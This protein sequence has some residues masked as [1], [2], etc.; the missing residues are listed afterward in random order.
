MTPSH[1]EWRIGAHMFRFEPPDLLRIE[2]K[3]NLSLEEA[4]R[5]V[6]LYRE[7]GAS[8][9]LYMMGCMK[10]AEL[11]EPEVRQYIS[12]NVRSEWFQATV[13]YEARLIHKALIKGVVLAAQLIER[14][15]KSAVDAIQFTSTREQ[16]E[17]LIARLRA[18]RS[19]TDSS[20]P[21]DPVL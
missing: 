19:G 4:T 1:R 14:A 21:R 13:Y 10:D 11:L 20:S 5:V 8:R 3:G 7:L 16:A 17:A 18:R 6:E 12:E 9:P 15:S 2:F